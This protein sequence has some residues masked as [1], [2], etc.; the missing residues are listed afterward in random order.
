[1][2][3]P[4]YGKNVSDTIMSTTTALVAPT[5]NGPLE[6]Q[7]IKVDEP[8]ADE[9]LVEIHAAGICH[10]DIACLRGK[11]H[12]NYP[13]ILGHEGGLRAPCRPR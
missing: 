11:I 9:A 12:V 4:D 5:L 6:F 7:K 13:N 1:M 2:T 3:G 10:A 8:R